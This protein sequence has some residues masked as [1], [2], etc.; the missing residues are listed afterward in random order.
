MTFFCEDSTQFAMDLSNGNIYYVDPVRALLFVC[1]RDGVYCKTLLDGQLEK[2]VQIV[3]DQKARSVH[4]CCF[5]HISWE[6][7]PLSFSC[8]YLLIADWGH[9]EVLLRMKMDG[10]NS[11]KKLGFR[12]QHMTLDPF[13]KKLFFYEPVQSTIFRMNYEVFDEPVS[14]AVS[15]GH[16]RLLFVL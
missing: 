8:S 14:V 13:G 2:P 4:F 1:T 15:I 10:T 11:L 7:S 6:L 5:R 16:S 12:A 9:Q 3:I